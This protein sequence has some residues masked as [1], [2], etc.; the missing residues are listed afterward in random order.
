M[1]LQELLM[2]KLGAVRKRRLLGER[3]RKGLRGWE[4]ARSG[5]HQTPWPRSLSTITKWWE[6]IYE[7]LCRE[8]MTMWKL[9]AEGLLERLTEGV[10]DGY[11]QTSIP[12]SPIIQSIYFPLES[13]FFRVVSTYHSVVQNK[14]FSI[15]VNVQSGD[16]KFVSS[17][18]SFVQQYKVL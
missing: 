8:M 14:I 3:G 5:L 13:N 2:L 7:K 9:G 6:Q 4:G 15:F 16:D 18:S 17:Y 10:L 1:S 11:H 12:N